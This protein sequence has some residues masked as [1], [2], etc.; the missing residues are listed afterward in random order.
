MESG[1][2]TRVITALTW[3]TGDPLVRV[4][5]GGASSSELVS[6]VGL[7]LNYQTDRDAPR[8]CIGKTPF[9]S[10]D[11][12]HYDC[13]NRPE[14]G[15]RLCTQCSIS[16]ATFASSLHHAHTK[17]R[18]D[19][20]PAIA[21]HLRQ[22]NVLYLAAFRD[23]SVKVG[24]ST[25]KRHHKR[26]TEQGAWRALLV[27]TTTDGYAVR[28]IEDRITADLEIPQSVSIGRKLE[29]MASPASDDRLDEELA[30]RA[31][32]VRDLQDR[33]S[34]KRIE[35]QREPWTFP[36]SDAHVWRALH[37]YPVRL[38]TGQHDL[39]VVE[40]CGR[41]AVVRRRGTDDVFAA[42]LGQLFG[43]ELR[44]GDYESDEL[45]VQDSLF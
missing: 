29:G 41:I 11:G 25:A 24:T 16:D 42:D 31:D 34:D 6:L 27:A 3:A 44:L 21:E 32:Q 13:S 23:G 38:D 7:V 8:L 40:A 20:D 10:A 1:E 4:R 5:D 28:D 36:G 26:L 9:R 43:I 17:D 18:A 45:A 30:W 15:S 12:D 35:P 19:I 2:G 14:S 39:E 37:R 33:M 22:P